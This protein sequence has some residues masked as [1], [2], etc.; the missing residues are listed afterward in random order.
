VVDELHALLESE[1]GMHVRS[2][3]A[4][5]VAAINRR[6]RCFGLSATLGDPR[7]ARSFLNCDNPASVRV[8]SDRSTARPIS[9]EVVS[10]GDSIP[11][12]S[13]PEA[14]SPD[15]HNGKCVTLARIAE[16]LRSAF[17]DG[18]YLV[19]AN[20]RRTVEELGDHLRGDCELAVDGE[21]VVML[22][23]GSLS[24]RLRKRTESMLKTGTPT[25]AI[26]TSSLEL[27]IDIGAIEAVAQIDPTWSV[28]SMVQRLGRSGRK[29]G[30]TSN[31]RLYV[32]IASLDKDASV[33]DLL[34]PPLLQAVAMVKLMLVGWLETVNPTRMHLSTLVHQ[35]LSILKETGGRTALALYHSLCR[36]GPFRRV[37]PADFKLLLQG[38][39]VHDLIQQDAEG[40]LFLG[41]AGE[42]I[43]SAPGFYAAFSTPVELVVRHGAKHL[44]RLPAN[45]SL[46][47][48]E[49]LLLNGRRWIV[50]SIVWRSKCVWVSP[51]LIRKAP[52]FLGGIGETHDYIFQEM[53]NVLLGDEEP[54]WLDANSLELLGSA[55]DA[56][57][58][59]GLVHSDLLD[60][61]DGV[62]W[63]A[64]TGTRTMRTLQLWAKYLGLSCSKDQL[65]FT[66][67]DVSR[68]D[69]ERHLAALAEDGTDAVKMAELMPNK[70]VE[71]FDQYVE[72]SLLDKANSEYR[73]DVAGAREAAR[74]TLARLRSAHPMA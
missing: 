36:L 4:R 28:A 73:L 16:D 49:C 43:T 10:I 59:S 55:R 54:D 64:W 23:H 14:G 24:A 12:E 46:K 71:R 5:L 6:P 69:L 25:R 7:A 15:K 53:R 29:P 48:G 74:R 13:H 35:V 18:S 68:A 65:S 56:A 61:D 37:E 8:I 44:G 27:G 45:R 11:V 3:L 39:H 52:V 38:L 34:H 50:D 32:R 58:R 21:P 2:L 31:L 66:F 1:R 70:Q 62:Q 20:S 22:H 51:A 57:H 17:S 30:S 40:I 42:R 9:I 33:V 47:E 72:E 67:T 63:F 41:M 26:C 60:L 19:F